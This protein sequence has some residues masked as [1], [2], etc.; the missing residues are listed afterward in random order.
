MMTEILWDL[1]YEDMLKFSGKKIRFSEI[2]KYQPQISVVFIDSQLLVQLEID[3][4]Y[5]Y[6]IILFVYF[7]QV[8]YCKSRQSY[9]RQW[10]SYFTGNMKEHNFSSD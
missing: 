3:H 6:I 4:L 1:F 9:F 10:V 5:I 7:F 2:F 8:E